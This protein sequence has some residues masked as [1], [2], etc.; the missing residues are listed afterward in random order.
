MPRP[1]AGDG[2]G[3]PPALA[4]AL[5]SRTRPGG[6]LEPAPGS[7]R[8][9]A[10]PTPPEPERLSIARHVVAPLWQRKPLSD[11]VLKAMAYGAA[12]FAFNCLKTTYQTFS[13][14]LFLHAFKLPLPWF[15]AGQ[16]ALG[17]W[18]AVDDSIMA[19]V[20]HLLHRGETP[21]LRHVC[22]YFYGGPI[23]AAAYM[24]MLVPWSSTND[25]IKGVHN[26]V[27][28]CV[29]DCAASYMSVSHQALGTDIS[30]SLHVRTLCKR[31]EIVALVCTS[32]VVLFAGHI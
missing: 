15:Y 11:D 31:F 8:K 24:L 5:R 17:A 4:T 16:A 30:P 27:S 18:N 7:P 12:Y 6:G 19:V 14:Q 22:A 20:A 23:C 21:A 26:I 32:V 28:I 2:A 3:S 10:P 9:H 13:I 25:A 1:P 29:W